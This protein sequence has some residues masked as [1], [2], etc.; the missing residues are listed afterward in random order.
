MTETPKP[1]EAPK[2]TLNS[3]FNSLFPDGIPHLENVT[4][5]GENLDTEVVEPYDEAIRVLKKAEGALDKG[6]FANVADLLKIA[7]RYIALAN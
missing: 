5:C 3:F 4:C 1:D 7:D 2:I 6:H